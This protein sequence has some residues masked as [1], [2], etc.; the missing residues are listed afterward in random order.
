MVCLSLCASSPLRRG[1]YAWDAG[2]ME[3]EALVES[4]D[5]KGE[6]V[7]IIGVVCVAV[8]V[9]EGPGAVYVIT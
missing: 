4:V 8:V 6:L 9:L 5:E 1:S 2:G 7:L 3:E